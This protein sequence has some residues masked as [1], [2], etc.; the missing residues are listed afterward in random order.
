MR[1]VVI[2]TNENDQPVRVSFA[3]GRWSGEDQYTIVCRTEQEAVDAFNAALADGASASDFDK[4][5]AATGRPT[6]AFENG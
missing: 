4:A 1:N 3:T 5:C 2:N 6:H